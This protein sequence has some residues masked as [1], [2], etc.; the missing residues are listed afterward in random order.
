MTAVSTEVVEGQFD[1]ASAE[2]PAVGLREAF[3][4]VDPD[5]LTAEMVGHW[6][7]LI[8]ETAAF[9]MQGMHPVIRDVVDRYSVARTDPAGRAIR[10]I[11]SVLRWTYGGL[12]A[13]AEGR[14]LRSLHQPLQMKNESGKHISALDPNAYQWVIATAYITTVNAGPLLIGR[15]FTVEEEEELLAD[16]RRLAHLLGVPMRD[17]PASRHEFENYLERMID[18]I[19]D[20]SDEVIEMVDVMRR[21][22]LE[23]DV[24]SRIPRPVRP[25]VSLG[26]KPPLRLMYLSMV[27]AMDPRIRAM[28]N[29]ELS[30][31]ERRT[32]EFIFSIVRL[33]YKV[34]PDRL[35]YFP[36]AYH[37][38][39]HHQCV[40]AMKRRE[41]KSAAYKVRPKAAPQKIV[42]QVV[43]SV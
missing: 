24:L 37:A 38:R 8:L 13:I 32:V 23:A 39:K 20:V 14:R 29:V 34:L 18:T 41:V 33:S 2:R 3:E 10:S 27:A 6:T 9:L 21:G 1:S 16:N 17:Y 35:T 4:L 43:I 15:S 25:V 28:L 11:D 19:L 42:Q 22:E 40:Q 30:F 7:Y 31:R 26:I 5:S 12:E 36:L